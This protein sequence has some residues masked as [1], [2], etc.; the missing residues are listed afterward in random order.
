MPNQISTEQFLTNVRTAI[1]RMRD[2]DNENIIQV[3]YC[4]T[5]QN[6]KGLFITDAFDQH[7]YECTYNG[8]TGEMYVDE[9]V[10]QNKQ[11]FTA[12]WNA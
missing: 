1:R 7:F 11:I 9:Y 4:K 10:K 8:D 6:H 12:G 5:I 3:W 2:S